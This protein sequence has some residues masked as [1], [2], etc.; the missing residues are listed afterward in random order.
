MDPKRV[1]TARQ[2]GPPL[3]SLHSDHYYP[4]VEPCI[5]TG[6]YTMSAAVLNLT[7]KK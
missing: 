3:P 2:G 5:R 1:E 6:V 4:I 7:G